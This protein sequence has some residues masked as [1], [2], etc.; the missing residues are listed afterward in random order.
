ME[1][2]YKQCFRCKNVFPAT[3]EYFYSDKSKPYG[4][5]GACRTCK[6]II[7][8]E[9]REANKE[10]MAKKDHDYREANKE[11]CI[12]RRRNY[13]KNNREKELCSIKKYYENNRDSLLEYAKTYRHNNKE[14]R[15]AYLK[16]NPD[17]LQTMTESRR[18]RK[19]SLVKDFTTKQWRECKSVFN[20]E[21]AYCGEKPKTLTQDHFI[22]M[23]RG[24][25][26]TKSNIVPACRRCN[27]S[28]RDED[29]LIWYHRQKFYDSER[30]KAILEYI[31]SNSQSQNGSF[32]LPRELQVI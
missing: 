5:S 26:L 14:K 23:S 16:A 19:K 17:V 2:N 10:K 20:N 13:Y 8:K 25:G 29:F 3:H 7:D 6:K 18:T 31:K 30:E 28:K 22:P 32:V 21:C 11:R 12:N 9:Y 1:Q 15:R 27:S 24:G 4:L